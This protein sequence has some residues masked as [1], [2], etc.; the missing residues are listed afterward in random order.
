MADNFRNKQWFKNMSQE[1]KDEICKQ[2]D[3]DEKTLRKAGRETDDGRL[4]ID[5]LRIDHLN[6][7]PKDWDIANEALKNH[8]DYKNKIASCDN[9]TELVTIF[10][11]LF[12]LFET[13]TYSKYKES[14]HND[15]CVKQI[16]DCIIADFE[17]Y[18]NCDD[19][20][21]AYYANRTLSHLKLL[22]QSDLNIIKS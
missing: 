12:N 16:K 15:L 8:T 3:I 6:H 18:I 22:L 5:L 21:K 14:L 9:V 2:F 4:V 17:G 13:H 20:S 10:E 7:Y 19:D 1:R 11:Q